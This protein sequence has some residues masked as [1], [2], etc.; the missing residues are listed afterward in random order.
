MRRFYLALAVGVLGLALGVLLTPSARDRV[1]GTG[2]IV[3]PMVGHASWASRA[4]TVAE[5]AAEADAIVLLRAERVY[6]ARAVVFPFPLQ[7]HTENRPE[8]DAIPFTDTDMRVLQVFKGS[9]VVGDQITVMQ[10][11]GAIP[12][13]DSYPAANVVTSDDP[14]YVEGR[15]YL[16]FLVDESRNPVHALG[17]RLFSFTNPTG[18]YDVQ[19]SGLTSHAEYWGSYT[20]PASLDTLVREITTAVGTQ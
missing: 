3:R 11:G 14:L 9:V 19:N 16:L 8:S 20:P 4:R 12:A 10:T 17:R 2:E 6:P 13:T 7:M 18:R 15:T 5:N 1:A